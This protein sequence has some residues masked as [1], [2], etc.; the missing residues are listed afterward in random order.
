MDKN[1][2][3]QLKYTYGN[4]PF[5]TCLI[6]ESGLITYVNP[7]FKAAI[8]ESPQP[9]EGRSIYEVISELIQDE[10]LSN[11]LRLLIH[12]D[13][14]FSMMTET[15]TSLRLKSTGYINV[16]GYKLENINILVADL[17]GGRDRYTKLIQEALDAIV[18][19][20]DGKI[21][22]SN[23]SFADLLNIDIEQIIG[24]KLTDFIADIGNDALNAINYEQIKELS[25]QFKILTRKGP[26]ILDGR[27]H[28]IE[29][30]PGISIAIMRDITEDVALEQRLLRQNQDLA[31]INLIS[32]VLSSSIQLK[33]VLESTL[34]KILQ[35]MNI[36]TGWIFI[37]D[38]DQQVLRCAYS[39]GLPQ[40]VIDS[41]SELS[42]GE[43]IAGRVAQTGE[44]IVIENASADSRISSLAFKEQGIHSFASIPLKS[45]TRLI[46]VM[47]IGSFGQRQL[48]PEDKRLLK[49][50]GLHM[51]TVIENILL[52]EEVTSTSH[53]LQRALDTIEMRNEELKSLVD[54]VTHDLKSPII[55]INGFCKRLLKSAGDRLSE[56]EIE[57]LQA[58]QESGHKM[59]SFVMNLLSVSVAERQKIENEEIELEMLIQEIIREVTPQLD[60]KDGRIEIVGNLPIITADRTRIS[61]I[62]S[63]LITNA[64]K[65]SHPERR[66]LIQIGSN[67]NDT[68]LLLYVRDNGIG[69]PKEHH[70]NIFDI[71]FRHYEDIA[72]GTGIGLSIVQKAVQAMQGEVWIESVEEGGTTFFVA[73]PKDINH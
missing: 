58:I 52:F 50:I 31:V 24:H 16:F 4:A 71:F 32:E 20:K 12:D 48:S 68:Q 47:N 65:Y 56:R 25:I 45:R 42:V 13:I 17:I 40:Y 51:G 10:G 62:F 41:I 57:Y 37:L 15:L 38:E 18:I 34:G 5:G 36:E 72:E 59:E 39:Y 64:I 27:I 28:S 69:I 7:G 66:P 26:R 2:F 70:S 29:D 43:G 14:P 8:M 9:F 44:P 46:G 61:Q 11:R 21:I 6:D 55:A 49:N 35:V 63:N 60:I 1:L 33:A 30:R 73:L 22:F 53:E 54:T 19:M 3:E 67:L 23:Y